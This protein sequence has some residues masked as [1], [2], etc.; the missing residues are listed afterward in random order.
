MGRHIRHHL[1]ADLAGV[2]TL[3]H[4]IRVHEP[5]VRSLKSIR[6]ARQTAPVR[7]GLGVSARPLNRADHLQSIS[8]RLAADAGGPK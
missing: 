6:F 3:T 5:Q 8:D 1:L 4:L 7:T 2:V